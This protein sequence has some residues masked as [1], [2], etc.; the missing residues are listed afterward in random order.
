MRAKAWSNGAHHSTGAG[1]GLKVS[2]QDRDRYFRPEW[3]VV[4]L[5]IPGEGTT[6][7]TLSASFWRTCSELRSAAIGRWLLSA[8]RAPWPRGAPP[9][10]E[11]TP[12]TDNHFIVRAD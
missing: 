10:L 11:L 12:V 8:G 1:Y 6:S 9:D 2:V 4:L 7:V 5:E 3:D